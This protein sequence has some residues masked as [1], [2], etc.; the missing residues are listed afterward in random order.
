MV[1]R[2]GTGILFLIGT[3]GTGTDIGTLF[4][5]KALSFCL[6][7]EEVRSSVTDDSCDSLFLR[8]THFLFLP[9]FLFIY[10]LLLINYKYYKGGVR[11]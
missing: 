10:I 9:P 6:L 11:K 8:G 5:Y 1:Y 7:G 2:V 4:P 3:T